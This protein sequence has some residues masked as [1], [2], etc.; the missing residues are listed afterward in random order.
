VLN[1]TYQR[2]DATPFKLLIGVKM[3]TDENLT[4]KEAIEH[5]MVYY[6]EDIRKQLKNDGRKQIQ[7][8]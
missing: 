7:K 4:M 5:E 3:K 1:S 6:Y 8:V 2:I